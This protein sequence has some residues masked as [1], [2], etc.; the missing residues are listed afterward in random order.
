MLETPLPYTRL[1]NHALLRLTTIYVL[2]VGDDLPFDV[3]LVVG[4]S[5]CRAQSVQVVLE[6]VVTKLT[7]L[8]QK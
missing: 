5:A 2:F 8:E 4:S 7:D 6:I 3:F 1:A